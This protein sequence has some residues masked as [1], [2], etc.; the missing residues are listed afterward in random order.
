MTEDAQSQLNHWQQLK[1]Q[2][3][4]GDLRM[5]EGI[6]KA[7]HDRCHTFLVALDNIKRNARQLDHLSG[8]GGLPSAKDMKKKFEDK[9]V[10]GGETGDSAIDRIQEHMTIIELMRDTYAAAIGQLQNTDQN[11][12]GQMTSTGEGAR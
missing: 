4:D 7:L 5:E 10:N 9:A 3:V 8:F 12:A 6:G 2:A 1:Q 11:T